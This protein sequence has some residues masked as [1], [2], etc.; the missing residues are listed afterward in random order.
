MLW[1][2]TKCRPNRIRDMSPPPPADCELLEHDFGSFYDRHL[3]AVAAFVGGRVRSADVAFDVVAETFARALERRSQY[4]ALRGPAI[5][6]LL[7]IARNLIIDAA[8]R[9]RVEATSR[10]KLGMAPIALH[11]DQ[12]GAIEEAGRADLALALADLPAT[13]RDAVLRRVVLEMP[14][15]EIAVELRCSEQV[16]RQRVSRGLSALRVTLEAER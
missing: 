7:G 3:T 10:G 11:D 6:W 12:L 2:V 13:Q 5:A 15:S 14:Y 1:S 8:R 16:I 9:G 4:D